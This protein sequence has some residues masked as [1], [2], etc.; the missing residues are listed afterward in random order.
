M[1]DVEHLPSPCAVVLVGPGASGKSTWAAAHF[2]PDAIVSSDRLR[3]VVGAGEGDQ[4]AS[5]DAFA[6]LEEIVARRLARRLTTVIDTLGLDFERRRRW[7]EM[8][9]RSGLACVAVVFDTPPRECERRNRDRRRQIPVSVLSDQ[10]RSFAGTRTGLGEE[11]FDAVLEAGPVRVVPQVFRSAPAA[12]RRQVEEPTGLR[13]G[14]HVGEFTF[15]GGRPATADALRTIAA[16]AEGAGFDSIYVMDHFR[17]IPQIGR[18][19]ADFLESYTTLA[20]LAVC[21]ERVRLGTLVT[22][23]TYRNPAHLAKI[24]A[25]LDVLSGGRA[26]CGIGLAWFREEH[27]AYGW[28]FPSVAERYELLED[29]LQLLPLIGAG[30]APRSKGGGCPCPRRCATRGRYKST[31]RSCSVVEASAAR[32]VSPPATPMPPT[33]SA[34][35]PPCN[36]RRKC[37]GPTARPKG[38]TRASWASHT[39]RRCSSGL[40][41]TSSLS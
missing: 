36:A 14:L 22:G 6:L 15:P 13:F 25:T 17:Q 28:R 3:A 30:A 11:G 5:E 23:V 9:R 39:C 7:V 2:P 18:P 4:S 31:C 41:T 40:T 32:S 26:V 24:V 19:F 10:L 37:C 16:A 33:C 20:Y 8:A 27:V 21:T 38:A 34:T 1:E 35:P 29:T 12:V